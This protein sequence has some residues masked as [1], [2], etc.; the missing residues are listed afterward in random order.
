MASTVG[1]FVTV[2]ATPPI[3]RRSRR[4]DRWVTAAVV[5]TPGPDAC[6]RRLMAYSVEKLCFEAATNDSGLIVQSQ[7]C[8][9]GGVLTTHHL[10]PTSRYGARGGVRDRTL[11]TAQ[12]STRIRRASEIEFFNRIGHEPPAIS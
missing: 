8:A 9:H 3:G 2:S 11:T 6:Q 4:I 1:G 7:F 10:S 12:R 5:D